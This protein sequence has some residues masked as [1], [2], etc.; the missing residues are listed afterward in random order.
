MA[1]MQAL[2]V[3]IAL[4][5]LLGAN[6]YGFGELLLHPIVSL[7]LHMSCAMNEAPQIH[8]VGLRTLSALTCLD[9]YVFF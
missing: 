3:D 9:V 5:A 1:P 2:G 8:L 7:P 4:A 6:V